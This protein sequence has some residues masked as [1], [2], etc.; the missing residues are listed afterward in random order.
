MNT[1]QTTVLVY[2]PKTRTED[3][4]F[5]NSGMALSSSFSLGSEKEI[6]SRR[7]R[8]ERER[9][10]CVVCLLFVVVCISCVRSVEGFVVVREMR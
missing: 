10:T 7:S 4:I 3:F 9:D 5:G 1:T 6:Q 8:E 2:I